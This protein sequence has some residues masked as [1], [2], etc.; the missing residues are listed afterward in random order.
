V[1]ARPHFDIHVVERGDEFVVV[2]E[3]EIDMTAAEALDQAIR[4]ARAGGGRLAIDLG[5][6]TFIDSQGLKVLLTARLL[7]GGSPSVTLRNLSPQARR[8]FEISGLLD[9]FG[10]ESA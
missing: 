5:A 3:G 9:S 8:T 1:A 10:V 6:V 4:A 2:A 7:G